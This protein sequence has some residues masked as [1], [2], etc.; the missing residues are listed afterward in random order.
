MSI[1]GLSSRHECTGVPHQFNV[2]PQVTSATAATQCSRYLQT[3]ALV[4]DLGASSWY[5]RVRG[6]CMYEE[7]KLPC[8]Q[9]N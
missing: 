2:R 5:I 1:V 7:L 9:D 6:V 4:D 3:Y 8:A